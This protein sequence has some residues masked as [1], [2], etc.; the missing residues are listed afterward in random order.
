MPDVTIWL[1]LGMTLNL[2]RS[3][4]HAIALIRKPQVI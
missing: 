1:L 3:T 4:I 2:T